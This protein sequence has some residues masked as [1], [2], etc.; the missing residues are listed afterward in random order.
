MKIC[1][2]LTLKYIF[3]HAGLVQFDCNEIFCGLM[4][5][6]IYVEL[7]LFDYSD[8]LSLIRSCYGIF[9]YTLHT[10]FL[11]SIKALRKLISISQQDAVCGFNYN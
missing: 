3:E 1:D 8:C 10:E 9:L 11:F 6:N 5:Q 2:E 7:I 4:K